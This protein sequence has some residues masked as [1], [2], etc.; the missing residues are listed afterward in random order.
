MT[1]AGLVSNLGCSHS[2][3]EV[4]M[5]SSGSVALAATLGMLGV[6]MVIVGKCCVRIHLW[7]FVFVMQTYVDLRSTTL[8]FVTSLPRHYHGTLGSG[9]GAAAIQVVRLKPPNLAPK[10]WDVGAGWGA[11]GCGTAMASLRIRAPMCSCARADR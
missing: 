4:Q 10:H 5:C 6:A 1:I 9:C 3:T 8:L 11:E 7:A 2:G